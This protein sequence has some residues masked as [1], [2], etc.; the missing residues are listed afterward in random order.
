MKLLYSV[1][2]EKALEYAYKGISKL[3]VFLFEKAK[4]GWITLVDK[5]QGKKKAK[6]IIKAKK[7]NDEN[8]YNS[9]ID[10]V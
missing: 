8:S 9:N 5:A 4:E 6:A 10:G 7:N 3:S 2:I 1:L